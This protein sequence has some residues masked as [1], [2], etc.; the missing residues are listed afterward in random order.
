MITYDV[1]HAVSCQCVQSGESTPLDFLELVADRLWHAHIYGWETDRHHPP[2]D[3]AVLG[4]IVDRLL[5]THCTWWTIELDDRA[6]AL[7]TRALLLDY[8]R[9]TTT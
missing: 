4:P 8:V 5:A 1:G 2:R 7:A 9:S 3:M 6:E